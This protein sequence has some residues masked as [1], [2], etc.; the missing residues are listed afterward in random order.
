AEI[1]IVGE[2]PPQTAK[3]IADSIK[4]RAVQ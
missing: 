2:L 4:F 1:T 3:R